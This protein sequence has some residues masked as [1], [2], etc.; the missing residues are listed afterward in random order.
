MP[1]PAVGGTSALAS[2][3]TAGPEGIGTGGRQRV[4]FCV[5]RHVEAL[6]AS[7]RGPGRSGFARAGS[8]PYHDPFESGSGSGAP[9][10]EHTPA[11]KKPESSTVAQAY[12]LALTTPRQS[13]TRAG[14]AKAQCL[15]ASKLAT[16]RAWELKEI[17]SHFW[18]YKSV[19][20][21]GGFLDY[22][23]FHAMRSRLEP[24]KQVA[25][26]LRAHEPLILNWFRAKGEI[27]NGAKSEWLPDDPAAS[28][29]SLPWKL[30]FITTWDD[31]EPESPHRFY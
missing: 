7:H 23:C 26:M 6:L 25:R 27:S 15:L 16:A 28:A 1:A 8:V 3:A 9:G 14:S 30:P 10:R 19:I 31:P 24:M 17:F 11:D 22:W 18:K 20:W 13:G 21:A 2:H 5:Q 12:A 29:P 4:A